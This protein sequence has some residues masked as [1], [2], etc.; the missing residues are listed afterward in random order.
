MNM[1]AFP[2]GSLRWRTSHTPVPYGVET[3]STSYW[4]LLL[5]SEWCWTN[6]FRT[7]AGP[8]RLS[9]SEATC[10]QG[11]Q[12]GTTDWTCSQSMWSPC[13]AREWEWTCITPPHV[14]IL[15]QFYAGHFV[16]GISRQSHTNTNKTAGCYLDANFQPGWIQVSRSVSGVKRQFASRCDCNGHEI[17]FRQSDGATTVWGFICII[18][19]LTI[20]QKLM[21]RC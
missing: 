9:S 2:W 11:E 19:R 21:Y 10:K 6:F 3:E 12:R 14:R 8:S 18:A 17:A 16:P 5:R 15:D 7:I 13:T 20:V 4:N 1:D